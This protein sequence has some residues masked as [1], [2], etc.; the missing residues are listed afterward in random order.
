MQALYNYLWPQKPWQESLEGKKILVVGPR[1][2][3]KSMLIKT[4]A[5]N[6]SHT[7][8]DSDKPYWLELL[9]TRD[10]PNLLELFKSKK[11][12][13]VETS[14][15]ANVEPSI[16]ENLDVIFAFAPDQALAKYQKCSLEHLSS[17]FRE[18]S[19][20]DCM[21]FDRYQCKFYRFK[22]PRIDFT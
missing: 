11:T 21:V 15:M 14:T 10:M 4:I 16:C 5:P 2:R 1:G 3:G 22:N 20:Y 9:N 18:C 8:D 13:I 19:G 6:A 12:V 17:L 7:L